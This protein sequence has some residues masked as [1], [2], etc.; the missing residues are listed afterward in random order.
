MMDDCKLCFNNAMKYNPAGSDVHELAKKFMAILD[1]SFKEANEKLRG[2]ENQ[3]R[4]KDNAC[5]LCGGERFLF[6]PQVF[7]CNGR[8]T[9]RIRRN[10]FYYTETENKFHW[11]QQCWNFL[12]DLIK[13]ARVAC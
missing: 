13:L 2:E 3:Q 4:A 8:C 10:S 11:C 5:K 6:E 12:P 1:R 7:Y 9:Q